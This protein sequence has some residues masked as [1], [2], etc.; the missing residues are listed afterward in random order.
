[1]WVWNTT[2]FIVGCRQSFV[3]IKPK[4]QKKISQKMF[5]VK[6]W[7]ERSHLCSQFLQIGCIRQSLR[8][9]HML[10][11]L[12][13]GLH[14]VWIYLLQLY[15]T[16]LY[17]INFDK[18]TYIFLGHNYDFL[19]CSS[20]DGRTATKFHRLKMKALFKPSLQIYQ[21]DHLD[22]SKV[23]SNNSHSIYPILIKKFC[24]VHSI[25]RYP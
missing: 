20:C 23:L 24:N 1:M 12:L 8:Y 13:P 21:Y 3:F 2:L 14:I 17:K 15:R 11:T 10:T 9:N 18:I 7:V 19:Y 6:Y 25:L 22:R 5:D 4:S 16:N